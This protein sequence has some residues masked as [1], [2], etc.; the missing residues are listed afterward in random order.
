M[1]SAVYAASEIMLN[2]FRNGLYV[3][4]ISDVRLEKT[5]PNVFSTYDYVLSSEAA[6]AYCGLMDYRTKTGITRPVL[7]A[8]DY[9]PVHEAEKIAQWMN[10][11]TEAL[12]RII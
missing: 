3:S 9:S 7:M 6:L 11:S 12:L 8:C 4:V 2:A 5:V 1:D 10:L